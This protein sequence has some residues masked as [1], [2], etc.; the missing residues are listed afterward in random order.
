MK[1]TPVILVVEDDAAVRQGI[2][3]TLTFSGYQVI[4][5]ADG[6]EGMEKALTASY[7]LMLLD[8]V[9]PYHSGFEVLEALRK[10]RPGQPTI[11]LSARGEEA[12]RVKGLTMGADDYVVKPFSVR[13]LLARVDAVLRRSSERT[14]GGEN[15]TFSGGEVDFTRSEVL[16]S[17]GARS[18][19]SERECGLLSYLVSNKGRPIARE[20]LLQR[21][22]GIDPKNIETR[23]I[24]MHIAHLREKLGGSGAETIVT[25]RGKGYRVG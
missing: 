18:E 3:D 1:N 20:E 14:A 23:T 5:A 2:C 12:D 25:V 13:E 22:W 7:Q 24:D 15:F 8:L 17:N 9:M 19:L 10:D 21:V 11:I 16:L 6:R 4:S